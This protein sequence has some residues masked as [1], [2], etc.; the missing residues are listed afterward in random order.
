LRVE[1]GAGSEIVNQKVEIQAIPEELMGTS[2]VLALFYLI[3]MYVRYIFGTCLSVIFQLQDL[4]NFVASTLKNFIEREDGKDEQK[5]LGFTFSFPVRQNSV[6]SGSLIRWT[7]GFSVGDTVS[8][9]SFLA[10]NYTF[11]CCGFHVIQLAVH[12]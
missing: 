6:S 3:S 9:L 4:F 5:A 11:Q 8:Q 2:E 1:V 10:H 7:K 12:N